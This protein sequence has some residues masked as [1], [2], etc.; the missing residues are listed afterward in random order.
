MNK[1]AGVHGVKGRNSSSLCTSMTAWSSA[2]SLS[3]EDAKHLL[4]RGGASISLFSAYFW[5]RVSEIHS[6]WLL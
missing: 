1:N 5:K 3:L 4:L 2:A 6:A